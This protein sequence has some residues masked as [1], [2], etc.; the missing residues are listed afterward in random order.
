MGRKNKNIVILDK[1]QTNGVI[2]NYNLEEIPIYGWNIASPKQVYS[3]QILNDLALQ[4]LMAK[5][6]SWT[7]N[8]IVG[9]A[10]SIVPKDYVD[11]ASVY[12]ETLNTTGDIFAAM[13]AR[14]NARISNKNIDRNLANWAVA[15]QFAQ[16][17]ITPTEGLNDDLNNI[18]LA[19][20]IGMLSPFVAH[21]AAHMIPTTAQG[22]LGLGL[23][24]AGSQAVDRMIR[25][26]SDYD[27]WTDMMLDKTKDWGDSGSFGRAAGDVIAYVGNPGGL[28]GGLS[29]A[30]FSDNVVRPVINNLIK[31]TNSILDDL[32]PKQQV[33]IATPEGYVVKVPAK[34]AGIEMTSN[35]LNWG[36][37]PW[38]KPTATPAAPVAPEVPTATP[39][40]KIDGTKYTLG[41]K[42]RFLVERGV[43]IDPKFKSTLKKSMKDLSDV[44]K[45]E[46]AVAAREYYEKTLEPV[47]EYNFDLIKTRAGERAKAYE[48]NLTI[49]R[50]KHM[51]E[52]GIEMPS[53]DKQ[54]KAAQQ[55]IK[56]RNNEI[57]YRNPAAK[58]LNWFT[59]PITNI[60]SPKPVGW[61]Q[62]NPILSNLEKWGFIGL[63]TM[64]PS[65]YGRQIIGMV[66]EGIEW[67]VSG[68]DE[69]KTESKEI[70]Q[71]QT[72]PEPIYNSASLKE[73]IKWSD[74]QSKIDSLNN[75]R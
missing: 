46:F 51:D 7:E 73:M 48:D 54:I 17:A 18:G 24:I 53:T 2:G 14:D 57:N 44:E 35:K 61:S 28:I 45:E 19:T 40:A 9:P 34:Q 11:P 66:P 75:T 72:E 15:K 21:G 74:E 41:P 30:N 42:N 6:S 69:N 26:T 10:I 32:I 43:E 13:T 23:G 4:D 63:E 16:N 27:G 38:S 58:K 33:A 37:W 68:P 65:Y 67:W 50:G 49:L 52:F 3:Q 20:G 36:N 39:A 71:N 8:P 70:K 56:I 22:W 5:R 29:F 64:L 47:N 62:N 60:F 12:A 31:P 59:H 55:A 1:P 25:N